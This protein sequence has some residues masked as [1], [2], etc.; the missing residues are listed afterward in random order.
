[1]GSV[2]T[3]TLKADDLLAAFSSALYDLVLEH[4]APP[5][6]IY[7]T[8]ATPR[9]DHLRLLGKAAALYELE[10]P[11]HETVAEHID[12]VLDELREA[13]DE[14]AAPYFYFGASTGDGADF[15]FWLHDDACQLIVDG[16]GL[17]VSDLADVPED[18]R[19]EALVINDHGNATLYACDGNG[20]PV[21]VWAV[22]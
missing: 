5:R 9:D 15:G 16:G 12:G 1:M 7:A 19:G 4:D 17:S 13:L 22:V 2:S 18:F 6:G 20:A 21:A 10:M 14:Y 3:G 11:D 8:D